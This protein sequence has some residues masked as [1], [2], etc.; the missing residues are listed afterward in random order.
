MERVLILTADSG[1]EL[2]VY[3]MPYRFREAG[4]TYQHGVRNGLA[5]SGRVVGSVH[6]DPRAGR[7]GGLTVPKTAMSGDNPQPCRAPPWPGT[8]PRRVG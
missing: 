3:Y 7:C 2:E 4:T 6:G 5:G 1:E 8:I